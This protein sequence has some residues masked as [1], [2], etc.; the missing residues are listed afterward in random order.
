MNFFLTYSR[1]IYCKFRTSH[2][3]RRHYCCRVIPAM[4]C[5]TRRYLFERFINVMNVFANL[6]MPVKESLLCKYW[7]LQHINC[8]GYNVYPHTDIC[9]YS[10]SNSEELVN[11]THTGATYYRVIYRCPDFYQCSDRPCLNG[12]TCE[13][14]FRGIRCF[15][16]TGWWGWFCETKESPCT[17]GYCPNSTG[18]I[19]FTVP[20]TPISTPH[21]ASVDV[22]LTL[23]LIFLLSAVAIAV[24]G[25]SAVFAARALRSSAN[26]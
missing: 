23:T 8:T 15:C 16:A 24:I 9:N 3:V 21:Y 2:I 11:Y 25:I 18:G 14:M 22:Q 6:T 20:R 13:T 10:I 7:C 17:E 1:H 19:N 4:D 26:L 12:A 5:L